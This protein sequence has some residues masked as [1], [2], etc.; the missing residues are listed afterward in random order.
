VLHNKVGLVGITKGIWM[1]TENCET[2]L[3]RFECLLEPAKVGSLTD[4]RGTAFLLWKP[5]PVMRTY[6]F[7]LDVSSFDDKLSTCVS[8]NRT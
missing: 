5:E 8:V 1:C 7:P 6:N 4:S 3:S 2:P